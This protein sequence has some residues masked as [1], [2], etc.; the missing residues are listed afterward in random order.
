MSKA[1]LNALEEELGCKCNVDDFIFEGDHTSSDN[2]NKDNC[3]CGVP[4][5][6]K[7]SIKHIK[8]NEI[9]YPI[10]SE[11]IKHF[12]LNEYDKIERFKKLKDF[13]VRG[14]K[15]RGKLISDLYPR[16]LEWFYENCNSK[17]KYVLEI[18]E[19]YKLLYIDNIILY[20][21]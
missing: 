17:K 7:Y 6:Y 21:K 1:L 5:L 16:T 15:Y 3:I 8:S 12:K 4:I 9:I 19:Y 18:Q 11:C 20:I 2:I 14:G 13:T 10:G